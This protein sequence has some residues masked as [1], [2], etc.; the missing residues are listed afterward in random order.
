MPQSAPDYDALAKKFGGTTTPDYDTIASRVGG[1]TTSPTQESPASGLERGYAEAF[2]LAPVAAGAVKGAGRTVTNLG[3]LALEA[4]VLGRVLQTVNEKLWGLSPEQQQ[5][6]LAAAREAT[7]PEGALEHIGSVAEQIAEYFLPA[8]KAEKTAT[9]LAGKLA[10]YVGG[11]A[12]R[13]GTEMAAQGAVGAGVSKAQGGSATVG[14]V[15]G[16]AGPVAAKSITWAA[17]KVGN[18]ARPLVRAGL[19]PTVTSMKQ[20]A[21]ASMTGINVQAEKLAK[22]ILDHKITTPARAEAIIRSAEAD[23]QAA[24]AAN[25]VPTDAPARA[26]H[27]LAALARAAGRQPL[28]RKD[29]RAIV[30]AGRDLVEGPMGEDVVTM[31]MKPSPI[32][33]PS[34]QPLMTPQAVV[35]RS[36]RDEMPAD[37]ALELARGASKWSNR[38]QYGEQKGAAKE[39]SKAVERAARDAVKRTVPGAR[40]ALQTEAQAIRAW[41]ALD[42]QAFREGN[43]DAMSLPGLVGAAPAVAQGKIPL[44]GLVAHWMRNNQIRAGVYANELKR[45]VNRGDITTVATIMTRLGVPM[46]AL[47]TQR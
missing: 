34:G 47:A 30:R 40:E 38:R 5:T 43:R 27:Y 46:S 7:T 1:T 17:G 8:A 12:A 33:G 29:V 15:A 14:A 44:L 16:A 20:Q 35:T 23:L 21:G 2:P 10:P 18:L 41:Q 6:A 22:F 4:P 9:W 45:A 39:A 36:L 3:Q 19:K 42:R 13:V 26:A 28:P 32:L 11:R 37:E 25:Q 31:V 24:I